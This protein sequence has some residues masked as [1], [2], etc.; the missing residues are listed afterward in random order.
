MQFSSSPRFVGCL[1]LYLLQHLS[2]DKYT[3]GTG[4]LPS[5][6]TGARGGGGRFAENSPTPPKKKKE[7]TAK[8]LVIE[9]NYIIYV[10]KY[11]TKIYKFFNNQFT[12][13]DTMGI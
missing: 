12:Y 2:M 5:K 8:K 7:S 6:L 4:T 1:T 3:F 13:V 11:L 9:I 10:L